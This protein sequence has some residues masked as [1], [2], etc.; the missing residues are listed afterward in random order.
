MKKSD[1]IPSINKNIAKTHCVILI[2]EIRNYSFWNK[3]TNDN[4][5]KKIIGV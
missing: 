5:K 4:G 2:M 1:W 3:P